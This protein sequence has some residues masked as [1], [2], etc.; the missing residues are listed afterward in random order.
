MYPVYAYFLLDGGG[1]KDLDRDL[2]REEELDL[3]DEILSSG[4]IVPEALDG[5]RYLVLLSV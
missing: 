2:D 4:K 5:K 3:I 1:E